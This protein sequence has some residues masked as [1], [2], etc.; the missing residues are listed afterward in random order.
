[1]KSVSNSNYNSVEWLDGTEYWIGKD[2]EGRSCGL[3][4]GINQ[5]FA[6]RDWK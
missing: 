6:W 3:I 2:V 5:W 1:M 4:W